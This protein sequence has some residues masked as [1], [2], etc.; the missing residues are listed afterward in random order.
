MTEQEWQTSDDPRAMFE[1]LRGTPR[2][3]RSRWFAWMG[4]QKSPISERKGMLLYH[5][6]ANLDPEYLKRLQEAARSGAIGYDGLDSEAAKI[7]MARYALEVTFNDMLSSDDNEGDV[8]IL[9]TL[10][11]QNRNPF[12]CPLLREMFNPFHSDYIDPYWIKWNEGTVSKLA[13]GIYKDNFWPDMPILA[14]ALEEAG[15]NDESILA[16]CRGQIN[17]VRGC[18]V[19]DLLLG[20]K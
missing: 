10:D 16:H 19:V 18:W 5:S 3:W 7:D 11:D 15:C 2:S 20:K 12:I 17:H 8:F 14:D 9:M 13:Q 1:F 4:M 6:A